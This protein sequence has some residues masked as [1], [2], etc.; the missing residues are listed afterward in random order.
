MDK[1]TLGTPLLTGI[2]MVLGHCR[3]VWRF[4]DPITQG[5]EQ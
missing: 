1:S 3:A 4:V 5:K 2:K